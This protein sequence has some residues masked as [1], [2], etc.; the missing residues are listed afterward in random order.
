MVREPG[1]KEINE[2]SGYNQQF[3]FD[4]DPIDWHFDVPF[5]WKVNQVYGKCA[6]T[7]LERNELCLT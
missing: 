3:V 7:P 4:R 6:H 1:A 2:L 5:A